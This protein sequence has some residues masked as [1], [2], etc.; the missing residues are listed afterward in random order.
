LESFG[1][2]QCGL[3][4]GKEVAAESLVVQCNIIAAMR[5]RKIADRSIST[6]LALSTNFPVWP[7]A[8]CR[9]RL[10]LVDE[11]NERPLLARDRLIADSPR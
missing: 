7:F 1:S 10:N 3:T 9:I 11:S 6:F 8:K 2:G 4:L 5:K